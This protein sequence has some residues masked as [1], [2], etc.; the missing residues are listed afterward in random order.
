MYDDK[1]GDDDDKGCIILLL[2]PSGGFLEKAHLVFTGRNDLRDHV[3][4][5]GMFTAGS[6]GFR[7]LQ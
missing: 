2:C 3:L 7:G 5:I 6:K 1:E 4:R